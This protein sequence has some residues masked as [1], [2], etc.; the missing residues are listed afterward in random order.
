MPLQNSKKTQLVVNFE[1][2]KI[3][4]NLSDFSYYI[5][6][7]PK[8]KVVLNTIFW[9]NWNWVSSWVEY[10]LELGVDPGEI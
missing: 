1:N 4:Y 2:K 6:K 7:L 8:G 9:N 3:R 10:Y 5:L